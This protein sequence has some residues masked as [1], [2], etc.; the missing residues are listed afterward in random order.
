MF[1]IFHVLQIVGIIAGL[2]CGIFIGKNYFGWFGI[3]SGGFL[4][5]FFGLI[6]GKI[7]FWITSFYLQRELQKSDTET[8]KQRLEKDYFISHLIVDELNRRG[9]PINK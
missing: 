3:V 4:G 8:L 6:F 9:E 5:V 1:T 2:I 7:P